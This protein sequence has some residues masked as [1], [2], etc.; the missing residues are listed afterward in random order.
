[1]NAL[2]RKSSLLPGAAVLLF[3][4]TAGAQTVAARAA[5]DDAPP[6]FQAPAG[7]SP[8]V[9]AKGNTYYV[10][11]QYL[12]IQGAIDAVAN[13]D[14]IIVRPGV[15]KENIV[16]SSSKDI[17]LKSEH[18]PEVTVIDA[19]YSGRVVTFES[20]VGSGTTLEGFTITAGSVMGDGAGILC[21]GA[22]PIIS[23]NHI[24]ENSAGGTEAIGGG[25]C[26][27]NG[28]PTI[29][30]NYIA[31]NYAEHEGGGIVVREGGAAIVNNLIQWNWSS[32]SWLSVQRCGG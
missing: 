25:I 26:C 17:M 30:N 20:V 10:P 16:F 31:G 28:A 1:M 18:G 2:T 27:V 21:D 12:T 22:S 29:I 5:V 24:I 4:M 15:Y 19:S 32:D 7:A 14:T 3:A 8:M 6:Q 11:D 9:V 23:G 13:D